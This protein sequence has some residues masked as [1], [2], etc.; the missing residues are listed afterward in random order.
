[1]Y[2]IHVSQLYN[3]DWNIK[4]IC[5]KNKDMENIQLL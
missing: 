5:N 3:E 2:E 4:A 1:M